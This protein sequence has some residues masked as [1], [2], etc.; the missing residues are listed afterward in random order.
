MVSLSKLNRAKKL[1]GLRIDDGYG[2]YVDVLQVDIVEGYIQSGGRK[3]PLS[4]QTEEY[5]NAF[6]LKQTKLIPVLAMQVR[7]IFN[8]E[9]I[10]WTSIN[11][12]MRYKVSDKT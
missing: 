6:V 7:S 8:P 12:R 3:V 1:V 10:W 2:A 5:K 4:Q 9:H 11:S